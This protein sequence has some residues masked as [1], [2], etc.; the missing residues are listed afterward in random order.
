METMIASTLSTS[1]KYCARCEQTKPLEQWAK[2]R[3]RK[4]GLQSMC[5][6]CDKLK[7]KDWEARNLDL[8]KDRQARYRAKDVYRANRRA[9]YRK[10]KASGT[11]KTYTPDKTKRALTEMRRRARKANNGIFQILPKEIDRLLSQNCF[12]CG[13]CATTLDHI[14]PIA[15]GGRHSIGNLLPACK[16]CNSSKKDKFLIAYKYEQLKG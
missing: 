15:K 7:N 12:Y 2:N 10:R 3:A 4:D 9:Y 6:S 8:V 11:L 5:K 14:V 1:G 13:S 16:S